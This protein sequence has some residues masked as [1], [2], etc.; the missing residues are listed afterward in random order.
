MEFNESA[1]PISNNKLNLYMEKK[2]NSFNLLANSNNDVKDINNIC[3]LIL[4]IY[5]SFILCFLL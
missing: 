5:L 3:L 2:N 1:P 4:L